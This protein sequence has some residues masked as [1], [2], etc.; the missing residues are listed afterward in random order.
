LDNGKCGTVFLLRKTSN[1]GFMHTNQTN[2][3]CEHTAES[4]IEDFLSQGVD[5]I[6]I[7]RILND[8]L[9]YYL[10]PT[11]DRAPSRT[12]AVE[13]I[14]SAEIMISMLRVISK[15]RQAKGILGNAGPCLRVVT[16]RHGPLH[17]QNH[18]RNLTPHHISVPA[19][20]LTLN[21][22]NAP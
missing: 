19:F 15:L 12:Y 16:R 14:D 3:N 18:N 8:M 21:P 22:Q 2:S 17:S 20:L 1:K 5:A 4:I 11:D 7:E 10:R 13:V 6:E 9:I